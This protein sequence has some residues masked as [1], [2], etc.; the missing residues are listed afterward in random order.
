[1]DKEFEINGHT[2]EDLINMY[3]V[4][5]NG[6]TF[7]PSSVFNAIGKRRAEKANRQPGDPGTAENPIF[8]NGHAYVY[9]STNQLILWED[10]PGTIPQKESMLRYAQHGSFSFI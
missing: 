7:I 1:M 8:M 10:F 4:Q 3:S 5:V 2:D 6:K 9:S